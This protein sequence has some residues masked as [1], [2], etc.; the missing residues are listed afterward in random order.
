M[1][2]GAPRTTPRTK[3]GLIALWRK[4][5]HQHFHLSV[6]PGGGKKSHGGNPYIAWAVIT[7]DR[8][9]ICEIES[10]CLIIPLRG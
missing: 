8:T 6:H 3:G 7:R 10:R 4:R 1:K 5:G 2:A 9:P